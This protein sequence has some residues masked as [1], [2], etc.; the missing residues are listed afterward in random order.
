MANSNANTFLNTLINSSVDFPIETVDNGIYKNHLFGISFKI[1]EGWSVVSSE[2]FNGER[3]KQTLS[4][5]FEDLKSEL[6]EILGSPILIIS[7]L[8]PE[9]PLYDGIVSPTINFNM[10][11][12][13]GEYKGMSLLDYA[14]EL[15]VDEEDCA[16]KAFRI[17]NK[18]DIFRNNGFDCIQFDTEYLFEHLD[19]SD[20]VMVEMSVLN[21]D[22]KDFFIDITMTQCKAQNQ[23]AVN[24]FNEFV[25]SIALDF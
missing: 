6:F 19:I 16:L 24:D 4:E 20:G 22:Y 8:D 14:N 13:E 25:K 12:K 10:D 17:L 21:I 15:D 18:G 23:M 11:I 9:N 3:Q 2:T 5:G 1:P 7:K